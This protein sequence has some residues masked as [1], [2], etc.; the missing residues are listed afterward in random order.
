MH[1]LV[2]LR[3]TLPDLHSGSFE[4]VGHPGGGRDAG[5]LLE[6]LGSGNA[7]PA[8]LPCLVQALNRPPDRPLVVGL[9]DLAG[10]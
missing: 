3:R 5:Q 2:A 4:R 8:R 6:I 7:L 1:D 10:I 9:G